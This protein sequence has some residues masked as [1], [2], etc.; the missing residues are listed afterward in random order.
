MPLLKGPQYTG[1]HNG[2]FSVDHVRSSANARAPSRCH[3]S[4]KHGQPI[5]ARVE[6]AQTEWTAAVLL[7]RTRQKHR[8][9]KSYRSDHTLARSNSSTAR[10]LCALHCS[11]RFSRKMAFN[12]R[13]G[14]LFYSKSRYQLVVRLTASILSTLQNI[15]V[16]YFVTEYSNKYNN[17]RVKLIIF[18][19]RFK[20][21][22][23]REPFHNAM[24]ILL[25]MFLERLVMLKEDQSDLSVLTQK[26]IIK[27]FFTFIQVKSQNN[28]II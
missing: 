19:C 15:R 20:A 26:Q 24:R 5:L 22:K 8:P 7:A 4:K 18:Y 25:P 11:E 10:R 2:A 14:S 27:L 13:K 6:A 12:C 17:L 3:L 21:A 9:R 28:H 1:F 16:K 23:D